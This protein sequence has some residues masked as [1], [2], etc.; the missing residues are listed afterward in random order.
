[1]LSFQERITA[2]PRG[3][4][5]LWSVIIRPYA[6]TKLSARFMERLHMTACCELGPLASF[7][8]V[9]SEPR[10]LQ[11]SALSIRCGAT[12]KR[13]IFVSFRCNRLIEPDTL[14]KRFLSHATKKA[15][16]DA[17]LGQVQLV[18]E[19]AKRIPPDGVQQLAHFQFGLP[20]FAEQE[21]TLVDQRGVAVPLLDLE[22][23][24]TAHLGS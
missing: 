7:A 19:R 17:P 6:S 22:G 5:A 2:D 3:V 11:F 12:L 10:S 4:R 24:P 18:H 9:D 16:A 21:A 20:G 1:M 23:D 14:K 8:S 13:R 15:R